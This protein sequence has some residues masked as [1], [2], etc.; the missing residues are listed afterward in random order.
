MVSISTPEGKSAIRGTGSLVLI[1]VEAIGIGDASFIFD[2]D[3]L[4]L[5]A[6]DARDVSSAIT[7][8]VATVQR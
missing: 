7:Q 4:R 1:D 3:T 2:K 5:V 6:T 8:G